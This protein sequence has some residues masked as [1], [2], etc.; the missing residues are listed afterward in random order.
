MHTEVLLIVSYAETLIPPPSAQGA[1]WTH[2]AAT[3]SVVSSHSYYVLPLVVRTKHSKAINPKQKKI[4]F[5]L[6]IDIGLWYPHIHATESFRS[7]YTERQENF[8][9]P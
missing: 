5:V 6:H 2:E 1:A 7:F 8:T 9:N 4:M 3:T